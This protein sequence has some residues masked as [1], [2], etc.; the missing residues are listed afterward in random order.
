[1]TEACQRRKKRFDKMNIIK[2]QT[3]HDQFYKIN[4]EL[5]VRLRSMKKMTQ[6]IYNPDEETCKPRFFFAATFS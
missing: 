6:K 1:M 4:I 5:Q 2:R 3:T